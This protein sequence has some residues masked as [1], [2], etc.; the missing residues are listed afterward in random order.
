[1][2][3]GKKLQNTRHSF[4]TSLPVTITHQLTTNTS[5]SRS[6]SPSPPRQQTQ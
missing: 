1:M 3:Y 5:A 4:P 2:H 6:P